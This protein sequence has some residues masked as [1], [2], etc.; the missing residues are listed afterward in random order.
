[1]TGVPALAR[2]VGATVTATGGNHSTSS[3]APGLNLPLHEGTCG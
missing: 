1:M 2:H 3:G